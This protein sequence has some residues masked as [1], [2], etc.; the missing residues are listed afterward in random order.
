MA[1]FQHFHAGNAENNTKRFAN[2]D[3]HDLDDLLNAAHS[4]RTKYNTNFDVTV[5]KV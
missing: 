1:N 4:K 3:A 2:L 5:Y